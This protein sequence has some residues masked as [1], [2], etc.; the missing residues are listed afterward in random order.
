MAKRA[1]TRQLLNNAF[2]TITTTKSASVSMNIVNLTSRDTWNRI[3]YKSNYAR[4]FLVYKACLKKSY[5]L[6]FNDIQIKVDRSI[7]TT[8]RHHH[9]V[10]EQVVYP[11]VQIS[12]PYQC[13]LKPCRRVL[14]YMPSWYK[15]CYQQSWH[16]LL[17]WQAWF[18]D[19]EP[20]AWVH[21]A[22]YR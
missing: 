22:E 6:D 4:R 19:W 21:Q 5:I 13:L 20:M 10:H 9:L 2:N 8:F 7:I 1:T 3:R 12:I 14:Q 18:L 17:A 11:Y 16:S 15:P